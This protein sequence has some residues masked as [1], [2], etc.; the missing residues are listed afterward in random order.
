MF[1]YIGMIFEKK[2][3][4]KNVATCKALDLWDTLP[5]TKGNLFTI[6]SWYSVLYLKGSLEEPE[7]LCRVQSKA[8][9]PSMQPQEEK[10]PL[11]SSQGPCV[12]FPVPEIHSSLT[13]KIPSGLWCAFCRKLP[14]PSHS[15]TSLLLHAST[16]PCTCSLTVLP[17][18]TVVKSLTSS[19]FF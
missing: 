4:A 9:V 10:E 3:G 6:K 17:K 13:Q 18:S 12:L 2:M 1:N 11:V 7:V 14:W 15:L 19:P 16:T 8:L 5:W